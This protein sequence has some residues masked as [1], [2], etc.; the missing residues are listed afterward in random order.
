MTQGDIA[1]SADYHYFGVLGMLA[2]GD[3]E[4]GV[5][6]ILRSA[7]G[8]E[9]VETVCGIGGCENQREQA[10]GWVEISFCLLN[11]RFQSWRKPSFDHILTSGRVRNDYRISVPS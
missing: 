6:E 9:E 3:S 11:K 10:S 1:S 8:F 5:A 7:V 2:L 4:K